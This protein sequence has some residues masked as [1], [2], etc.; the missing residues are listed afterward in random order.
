MQKELKNFFYPKTIAVIG[1]SP[2]GGKVGNTLIKKLK[3]FS[4]K[5]IPVNIHK[6]IIE[7]KES[8]KSVKEYKKNI[9]LAIIATPAKT[10]PG[11]LKKCGRKGIRNIIVISSGFAE[12]GNKRL[13]KKIIKI[14][15]RKKITLLGPNCFGTTEPYSGLDCTF[16]NTTPKRGNIAV[17]S[18]SGALWSY[19]SDLELKGKGFSG[20]VS[21]G[22][23]AQLD[24]PDFIEYFNKDKETKKI[25][26]YMEKIKDGKRF[27][28]VCRKSK[29]EILVVKA[30]Q[31]EEGTRAVISHTGSLATDYAVYKGI[32]NQA[33]IRQVDSL[34][35]AVGIKKQEIKIKAG[36][37]VYI[38]TNAGGS[39][40]LVTD[41]C[42]RKKLKLIGKSPL[43]LLGTASAEKY[44]IALEG[45]A[46]KKE[47]F[48]IVIVILTPQQMS[49][50][51]ETAK[52]II[53]FKH[54]TKKQ[55]L[56]I[57]LGEKSVRKAK[58][59]L[60]K[61]KITCLTRCC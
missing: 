13:E 9:D 5:V 56:P 58:N 12:A 14:A 31:T 44:K 23:M 18:Q 24:F 49:Q 29:K 53:N 22:N 42:K 54:K 51:L 45:V 43:D 57:F 41:Y 16:S 26:L 17:I 35:E 20:F 30:G 25:I 7:G 10:V 39:G 60:E 6:E 19:I 33:K 38:I 37:R 3:K 4:G 27:I 40:A 21:L 34:A 36:K 28:E 46:K 48:D 61:N 50:P 1:A 15:K 2:I 59:L 52:E 47:Y 32:F 55:V 11:I 8:Y